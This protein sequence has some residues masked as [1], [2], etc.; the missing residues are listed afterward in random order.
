MV[1][2]DIS[3]LLSSH[4]RT[5]TGTLTQAH[6]ENKRIQISVSTLFN[7]I[8]AIPRRVSLHPIDPDQDSANFSHLPYLTLPYLKK[9]WGN[10]FSRDVL[11]IHLIPLP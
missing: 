6:W 9:K 11:V 4:L 5:G 7:Y 8:I 3:G 2:A 10:P 1:F